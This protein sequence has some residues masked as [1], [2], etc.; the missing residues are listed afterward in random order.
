MGIDEKISRVC[1]AVLESAATDIVSLAEVRQI[2]DDVRS[3]GEVSASQGPPGGDEAALLAAVLLR[4]LE[5]GLEIGH[6]EI[7][8]AVNENDDYVAFI[9]W[10]GTPESKIQR[11]LASDS[12]HVVEAGFGAWLALHSNVD[13]YE[14]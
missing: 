7:G 2:A 1:E 8:H 5:S 4:A 14:T 3:G 6:A 13:R 10:R 11:A 9:G 12:S